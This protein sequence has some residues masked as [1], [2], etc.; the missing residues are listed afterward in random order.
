MSGSE[1]LEAGEVACWAIRSIKDFKKKSG[2]I[3]C[4]FFLKVMTEM[5]RLD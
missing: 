3:R 2:M 5:G 1:R 4:A